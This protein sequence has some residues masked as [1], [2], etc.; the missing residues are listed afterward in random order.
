MDNLPG[1]RVAGAG[2][3]K[4]LPPLA[5]EDFSML[6]FDFLLASFFLNELNIDLLPLEVPDV[7]SMPMVVV[8]CGMWYGFV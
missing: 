7:E 4:G 6:V 8:V 5:S 1:R 3:W 2:V